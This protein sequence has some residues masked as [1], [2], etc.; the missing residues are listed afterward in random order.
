MPNDEGPWKKEEKRNPKEWIEKQL[1]A[2]AHS[3]CTKPP[4]K[5]NKAKQALLQQS[6]CFDSLFYSNLGFR[7]RF[8]SPQINL[9]NRFHG[10]TQQQKKLLASSSSS[11]MA[12]KQTQRCLVNPVLAC[13]ALP[14]SHES[15]HLA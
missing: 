2:E 15:R 11:L 10:H 14:D 13:R 1:R 3:H 12:S 6:S 7:P 8:A 9:C 5:K 4:K